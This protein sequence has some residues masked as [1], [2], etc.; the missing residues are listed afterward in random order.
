MNGKSSGIYTM[1][2]YAAIKNEILKFVTSWMD[3][4]VSMLSEKNQTEKTKTMWFHL[5]MESKNEIKRLIETDQ[6]YSCQKGGG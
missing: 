4:E 1:E 2:Y 6:R 3:L 5:Y